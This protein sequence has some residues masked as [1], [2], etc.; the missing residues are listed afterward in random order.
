VSEIILDTDFGDGLWD[1]CARCSYVFEIL[2]DEPVDG[3]SV[4]L[5]KVAGDEWHKSSYRKV[6]SGGAAKRGDHTKFPLEI[7]APVSPDV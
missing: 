6:K 3:L 4:I 1:V 5:W 7:F 2:A